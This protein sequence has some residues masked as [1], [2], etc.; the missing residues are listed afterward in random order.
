MSTEY[1]YAYFLNQALPDYKYV[2]HHLLFDPDDPPHP[3][4]NSDDLQCV[5]QTR[6]V[7]IV[8]RIFSSFNVSILNDTLFVFVLVKRSLVL[9]LVKVFLTSN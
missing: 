4:V 9:F 8:T 2:D 1:W 7:T 5:S 6:L 3:P